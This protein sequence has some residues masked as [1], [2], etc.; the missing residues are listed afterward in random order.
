[1]AADVLLNKAAT[2]ERCVARASEEYAAAGV[3][4]KVSRRSNAMSRRTIAR[5]ALAALPTLLMACASAPPGAVAP[6]APTVNAPAMMVQSYRCEQAEG[7]NVTFGMDSAALT[8][9]RGR[10]ELLRDAGG[11]TP[12][13]TVYS[14]ATMRAEF[15]LGADG[16]GAVLRTVKPATVVRCMRN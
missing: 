2:I 6:A 7:F 8:G 13:Q 12:Q 15:G 5:C 16:R 3:A 10:H 1:M 11:L 4:A 14:N 9:P